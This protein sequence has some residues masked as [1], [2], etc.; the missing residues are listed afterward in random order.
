MTVEQSMKDYGMGLNEHVLTE[1]EQE[2]L[3]QENDE[4][5]AKR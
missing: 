2:E 4:E 5:Y 1:E 3:A